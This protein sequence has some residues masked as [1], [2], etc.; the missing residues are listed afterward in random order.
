MELNDLLSE[1]GIEETEV[2][3]KTPG[4]DVTDTNND[5]A[6]TGSGTTGTQNNSEA[7][8]DSQDDVENIINDSTKAGAA[9]AQMRSDNKRLT[10][11]I[12]GFAESLGL[13][14]KGIPTENLIADVQ[15]AL[16]KARAA[17]SNVPEEL[18][19][20]LD[21]LEKRD[22]DNTRARLNQE[23]LLG[24]QNLKNTYK[25]DGPAI[26]QFL[27]D[28]DKDGKNPFEQSVDLLTEY[29]MRHFDDIIQAA[30]NDALL[31]DRQRSSKADKHS[32]TP[33]TTVGGTTGE[34]EKINSYA[35]LT[36]FLDGNK[37]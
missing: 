18:L 24:L 4:T 7:T 2:D 28:L 9:F 31:A 20:R 23:A 21:T 8:G 19:T 3:N 30:V 5:T 14:T 11:T 6:D 27:E 25:L 36:K 10:D 17:Q 22:Q 1:L 32:S 29:K 16:I 15:T 37:A 33:S 35:D 12:K 13:N 34:Q 26:K